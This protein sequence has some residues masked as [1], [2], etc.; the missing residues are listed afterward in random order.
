MWNLG[1]TTATKQVMQWQ[2][3]WKSRKSEMFPVKP[4]HVTNWGCIPKM[5]I[6]QW[7]YWRWWP[8]LCSLRVKDRLCDLVDRVPGYRS[9][10]PDFDSQRYQIFWEVVGLERG[11]LSLVSTIE[12]LLGRNGSG[13]S[14]EIREYGCG[15]PLRWPRDTLYP[16]NLILPSPTS[17]SSSLGTVRSQTNKRV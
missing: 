8:F 16:Q 14:L 12:E 7:Q 5:I 3:S 6:F 11:P 9:R 4:S 10:S 1:W 2:R 13:S 17:G 15:D